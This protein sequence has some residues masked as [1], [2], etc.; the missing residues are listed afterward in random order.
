MWLTA[1]AAVAGVVAPHRGANF[2]VAP[3]QRHWLLLAP[4]VL[5]ALLLRLPFRPP[6]SLRRGLR[7]PFRLSFALPLSLCGGS[8]FLTFFGRCLLQGEI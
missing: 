7:S 2:G 4:S 8:L 3:C 6:S 5:P 1:I